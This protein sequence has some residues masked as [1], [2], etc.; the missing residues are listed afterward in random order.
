MRNITFKLF[1]NDVSLGNICV[2][3]KW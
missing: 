1:G 2:L 3:K